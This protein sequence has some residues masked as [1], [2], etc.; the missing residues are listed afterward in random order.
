MADMT[1]ESFSAWSGSST[2][3]AV[4]TYE[5]APDTLGLEIYPLDR[6]RKMPRR[7]CTLLRS[8]MEKPGNRL[9]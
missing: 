4:G 6:Y 9:R 5:P 3:I 1:Q 2:L 7:R 8:Q